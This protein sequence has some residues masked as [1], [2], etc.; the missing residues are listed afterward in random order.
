MNTHAATT[1]LAL[2]LAAGAAGAG[3]DNP[4]VTAGSATFNTSGSTTTITAADGTVI[5]YNSFNIGAGETVQF[6]QP[7]SNASVLNRITG[8]SPTSIDGSLLA[9]GRVYLVNPAGVMFGRNAVVNVGHLYAAAANIS[10]DDFLAGRNNFTGSAGSVVNHGSITGDFVSLV[11]ARVANHG[12]ITSDRGTV[13]MAAGNDVVISERLGQWHVRVDRAASPASPAGSQPSLAAGD[14]YSVAAWHDGATTADTIIIASAGDTAVSGSL[15]ASDPASGGLLSIRGADVTIGTDPLAL[16]TDFIDT[17]AVEAALNTGLDFEV[18]AAGDL[19]LASGAT[20]TKAAG[21]DA[22]L[23]LSAGDSLFLDGSIENLSAGALS[24]DLDAANLISI[25]GDISLAG[26]AL[27][28]V[29]TDI[30]LASIDEEPARSRASNSISAGVIE[31]NAANT[32]DVESVLATTSTIADLSAGAFDALSIELRIEMQATPANQ[33]LAVLL[34]GLDV[35]LVNP[36]ITTANSGGLRLFA[37]NSAELTPNAAIAL[38]GR[39]LQEGPA[40]LSLGGEI[41]TTGDDIL[42][43]SDATLTGDLLLNANDGSGADALIGFAGTIDG[44]HFLSADAGQGR[45]IALQD[46]GSAAQLNTLRLR[47]RTIDLYG[48]ATSRFR[49]VYVADTLTLHG[50]DL[51]TT[52]TTQPMGLER[53]SIEVLAE[54]GDSF[55]GNLVLDGDSALTTAGVSEDGRSGTLPILDGDQVFIAGTTNAL[56]GVAST[57][58]IDS[59][60]AATTFGG[61]VGTGVGSGN[62][63]AM[64]DV[65][66]DEARLF[67]DVF[68]HGMNFFAPVAIHS[69][70]A[71][72]HTGD[73]VALFADDIYSAQNQANSVAFLYTGDPA[74]ELGANRTPFKFRGWIGARSSGYGGERSGESEFALTDI[75]F[76][77]DRSPAT[78]ASFLFASDAQPGDA[79]TPG[80]SFFDNFYVYAYDNITMGAGQKLTSFGSLDIATGSASFGTIT[81]GDVNVLGNLTVNTQRLVFNTRAPG[82]LEGVGT[83]EDR[84]AGR[85]PDLLNDFGMELIASGDIGLFVDEI[86]ASGS[87]RVLALDADGLAEFDGAGFAPITQINGED[88]VVPTVDTSLFESVLSVPVRFEGNPLY[89]Y[90]LAI[91]TTSTPTNEIEP[92]LALGFNGVDRFDP[93]YAGR[94]VPSDRVLRELALNPRANDASTHRNKAATGSAIISDLPGTPEPGVTDYTVTLDRLSLGAVRRLETA[95]VGLF[96]EPVEEGSDI[97]T[98]TQSLHRQILNSWTD[99]RTAGGADAMGFAGWAYQNDPAFFQT[100]LDIRELMD[101]LENLGLTPLDHARAR[102]RTLD[103]LRPGS[104]EIGTIDRMLRG[105]DQLVIPEPGEQGRQGPTVARR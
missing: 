102:A 61:T 15:S 7:H 51:T 55:A 66:A 33:D 47:G 2:F 94:Y 41:T 40:G 9:N 99:Y 4:T 45:I 20:I 85:T 88:I 30:R 72:L 22:T 98:N 80:L 48:D 74:V 96:G 37:L 13:V 44:D 52:D 60:D 18:S 46:L 57:L 59:G 93:R 70:L 75:T 27:S 29:A 32:L 35:A 11:G 79:L 5:N 87:G 65:T 83:E 69:Q 56:G 28:A 100:L 50:S 95:Y 34:S 12:T 63:L 92:N 43:A 90:D 36:S 49:Q 89:A 19:T 16:S 76:G 64:L 81:L 25:A 1:A 86:I 31:L 3:P 104:L 39:F 78:A 71:T 84:I 68:T 8:G 91:T 26:G 103:R 6:V 82:V 10:N 73:G 14:Q 97:R 101:A 54:L 77:G 58:T 23:T 21:G 105:L 67:G 38:D 53:A 17:G 42:F 62:E 24:L